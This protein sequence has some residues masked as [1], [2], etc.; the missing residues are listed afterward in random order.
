MSSID[1][2]P[3]VEAEIQVELKLES[4]EQMQVALAM[5]EFGNPFIKS[6]GTAI[7]NADKT[8]AKKIRKAFKEEW[9]QYMTI[10]EWVLHPLR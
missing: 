2:P 3:K 10:K 5:Q 9:E 7:M 8:N 1:I 4:L 6:L